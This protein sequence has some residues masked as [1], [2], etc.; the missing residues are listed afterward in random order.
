M[1]QTG[2]FRGDP[3]DVA[4][5]K[6]MRE[7]LVPAADYFKPDLVLVSAGFDAHWLDLALNVTY[8][9]FAAMTGVVQQIADR[10]CNGRLAM[11]LEGGYNTK[12]LSRGVH[13]T[14]QVLAGGQPVEPKVCGVEEVNTAIEFHKGAFEPDNRD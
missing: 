7:L 13:A 11:V 9:G 2:R 5:L 14:L 10:H 4:Y 8:E 12:S 6:A 3:A 1:R